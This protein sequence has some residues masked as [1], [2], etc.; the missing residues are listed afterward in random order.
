MINLKIIISIIFV[1]CFAFK[2][3]REKIS[4]IPF[5]LSKE[6]DKYLVDNRTVKL[7]N[8]NFTASQLK[9]KGLN[10]L[11]KIKKST[12]INFV[13]KINNE[14]KISIIIPVYNCQN[15]IELT[16]KSINFQTFKDLEI[17]LVNDQSSDNS[18]KKIQE[19]QIVDQRINIINNKRNMGTLYSRCIGVLNAKG[20]YVIGLDNDDLFLFEEILETIYLNAKINYFDIVEVKSFEI[21]DYSPKYENIRNG[22]FIY[23]KNNIILHQP[24][25]SLFPISKNN[26]LAFTDHYIWGKCI[27]NKIYKNAINLLGKKRYSTYNC[28]T[29]D[30]SI[31]FILFNI[32]KSFIFL[33]IFGIFHLRAIT[34]TTYKL[35]KKKKLLTN[36]FYLG[37]LFDFSKNDNIIK[38][39]VAQYALRFSMSNLNKLDNK[40]KET[41]KSIIKKLIECKYITKDYKQKLLNKFIN[42]IKVSIKKNNECL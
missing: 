40:N 11:T 6:G 33:N 15:S 39:F 37:I 42:S 38:N 29:E 13:K 1:I 9:I 18:S 24:N 31:V 5:L 28:W 34:T 16:I 35:T 3:F 7:I 30:V 23:H 36:I 22:Y 12:L 26:K 8:I 4:I 10:Y 41:F 20:K 27:R 32:A 2:Y 21:S 25:L 19:L 14:P 17:I